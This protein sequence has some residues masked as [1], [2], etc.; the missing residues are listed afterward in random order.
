MVVA[1][2]SL[3]RVRHPEIEVI[4]EDILRVDLEQIL[5]AGESWRLIGNLPYNISSPL[6]AVLTDF[7]TQFPGR[8]ADMHFMLQREM[9]AKV[10]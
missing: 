1:L 3:L 8:V 2:V 4:N 10:S 6:L 9:A 7:V 5:E